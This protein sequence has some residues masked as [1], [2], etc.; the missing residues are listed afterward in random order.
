MVSSPMYERLKTFME[1]ARA[2]KGLEAW[3]KDHARALEYFDDA[4]ELLRSYRDGHGFTG[5][6]GTA[7]DRWV[8][9][10]VQRITKYREAYERGFR[11]YSNGRGVMATALAESEKISADLID[12]ETEAMRDDLVVAVPD[13][14]P[15]PGI[16]AMGKL[17]TTG[18]AYVEAVE[19]QAN[20]QREAAAERILTML[21]SSTKAISVE[22]EGRSNSVES[23]KGLEDYEEEERQKD[24]N[25]GGGGSN[26]GDSHTAGRGAGGWGY[27]SDD[28]FG[29]A[30]DRSS[31]SGNYPGGFDQP[32]WSEADA[33]AARSRIVSSGAVETRE[34]PYGELGSRTNPITDPQELMSRDL[35][36]TR[37]NGTTYRNG[38]VGG[39][40][41]APPQMWITHCGA[42]TAVLPPTRVPQAG[43]VEP[44]RSVRVHSV[45]AALPRWVPT[46]LR[47]GWPACVA[48]PVRPT[49]WAPRVPPPSRPAP[50]PVPASAPTLPPRAQMAV[51][52]VLEVLRA[53]VLVDSWAPEPA[54]VLGLA[55]KTRS[56]AGASTWPS[57]SRTTRTRCPQVT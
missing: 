4:V 35:L 56:V 30:K 14:E 32:W 17:F 44:A 38:V 45:C 37:V 42:S 8:D 51:L 39:H 27:S 10:S 13:S 25:S 55:R 11:S 28:D 49:A 23:G 43:S 46:E 15:G 24:N 3:D 21:N 41:P 18:A 7:M 33:A 20:A 6:T 40:T 22:M 19:A 47:E 5:A 12:A 1:A 31:T 52:L 54:L 57:S 34:L 50:T 26:G 2:N 16:R 48:S 9:A 36:H 53:E 29:R